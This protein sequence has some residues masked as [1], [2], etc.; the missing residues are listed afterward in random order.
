MFS[1]FLI[2]TK[3]DVAENKPNYF[4]PRSGR[5]QWSAVVDNIRGAVG[6]MVKRP[7]KIDPS[8]DERPSTIV[9]SSDV[10]TIENGASGASM[11]DLKHGCFA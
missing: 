7:S 11:C 3:S 8:I 6:A 1:I 10:A 5:S 2:W 9:P 4:G